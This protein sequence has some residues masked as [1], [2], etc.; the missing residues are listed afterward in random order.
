MHSIEEI[1]IKNG[2][3]DLYKNQYN[4]YKNIKSEDESIQKLI[5]IINKYQ[6]AIEQEYFII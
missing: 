5:D 3:V 1:I 2:S 4:R 6:K